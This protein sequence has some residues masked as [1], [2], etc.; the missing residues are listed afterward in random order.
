MNDEKYLETGLAGQTKK[1]VYFDN[2]QEA[3]EYLVNRSEFNQRKI[4][5]GY[6]GLVMDL[7]VDVSVDP[8]GEEVIDINHFRCKERNQGFAR[9]AM[10]RMLAITKE[11][12]YKRVWTHIRANP[13]RERVIEFLTAAGFD[14]VPLTDIY[15]PDP[16]IVTAKQEI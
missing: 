10:T 11:N 13:S 5:A 15:N 12:D 6:K 4:Q 9:Q 3:K 14:I 16:T 2:P 8:R 1:Q 7:P